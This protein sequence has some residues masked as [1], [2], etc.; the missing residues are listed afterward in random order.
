[1]NDFPLFFRKRALVQEAFDCGYE[2]EQDDDEQDEDDH[3][4]DED[5]IEILGG[6]CCATLASGLLCSAFGSCCLR[7]FSFR[8]DISEDVEDVFVLQREGGH[9]HLVVFVKEVDSVRVPAGDNCRGVSHKI[10]DPFDGWSAVVYASE[11]WSD[12]TR[13][14]AVTSFTVCIKDLLS[15]CNGGFVSGYLLRKT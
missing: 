6:A 12:Q 10:L 7:F 5:E 8:L 15:R 9:Q 14:Y 2:E 3:H 11:R 1:M 13:V 4:P